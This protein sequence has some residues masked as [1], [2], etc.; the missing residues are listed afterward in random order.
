MNSQNIKIFSSLIPS[1][2]LKIIK[3]LGEILRF[4]LLVMSEKNIFA[5]KLFLLLNI[6]DF[7][8]LCA[9]I[10]SSSWKKSSP[11]SQ[12][13]SLKA[14]VLPSPPPFWKFGWKFKPLPP[15]KQKGRG[16]HTMCKL[17]TLSANRNKKSWGSAKPPSFWKLWSSIFPP[18]ERGEC[19][20]C[21]SPWH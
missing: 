19:T 10:A 3:S 12:Q 2:L 20:L 15:V 13:P 21:V 8:F 5:C 9:K 1:Y 11:L 6:S 16:V 17:F 4:E 18:A 7:N 14:E